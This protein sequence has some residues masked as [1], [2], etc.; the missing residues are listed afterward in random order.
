MEREASRIGR[1]LLTGATGF[2]GSALLERLAESA[3]EGVLVC[4]RPGTAGSLRE[5]VERNMR[6]R[7]V[8][9]P[10][11]WQYHEAD[12]SGEQHLTPVIM[13]FEPDTIIHAAAD[14]SIASGWGCDQVNRIGT[15]R[16]LRHVRES[17]ASPRFVYISTAFVRGVRG[18]RLVR[19]EE[20]RAAPGEAHLSLYSRSKADAERLVESSGLPFLIVRPSIIIGRNASGGMGWIGELCHA[21]AALRRAPVEPDAAVDVVTIDHVL[22]VLIA[23]LG[24]DPPDGLICNIAAGDESLRCRDLVR[25]G[26][27]RRTRADRL[28]LLPV[29]QWDQAEFEANATTEER[30]ALMRIAPLLPYLNLDVTFSG[31][32][33]EALTGIRPASR[34][35][36]EEWIRG[37]I[38]A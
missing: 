36:L 19:E 31:S 15:R 11:H 20:G 25:I 26:E 33:V 10:K 35:A 5:R 23:L 1:V 2:L 12:L 4:G 37:F 24:G 17:G 21:A 8:D 3:H 18:G 16:L 7:G 14:T 22:E 6:V 30:Y 32:R 28:C 29:D 13:S 9:A 34:A 27:Q 38:A